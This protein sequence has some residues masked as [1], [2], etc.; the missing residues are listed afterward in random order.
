MMVPV[1]VTVEVGVMVLERPAVRV[2]VVVNVLEAFVVKDGVAVTAGWGAAGRDMR[3]LQAE[4]KSMA[5]R[6]SRI[7]R[8][9]LR[10]FMVKE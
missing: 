1:G 9:F 4:G 8:I 5:I 2:A 10:S 6:I 7:G 3:F